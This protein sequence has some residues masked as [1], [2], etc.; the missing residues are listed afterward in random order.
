ME[1]FRKTV[2]DF[3]QKEVIPNASAWERERGYPRG[4]FPRLG[5]LGYLGIVYPEEYGGM[6]GDYLMA[7][8]FVEEL[9]QGSASLTAGAVVTSLV[10]S[11]PIFRFGTEEQRRRYLVPAIRGEKVVAFGLTEPNAGSDVAGIQTLARREG[12]CYVLSGRKTFITN[13]DIADH[14]VV[15]AV[16][17]RGQGPKGISLFIVERDIPGFSVSRRMETMGWCASHTAELLFEDCRVPVA[18]L[19]GKEN[20]GFY[21]LMGGLNQG[22]ICIGAMSV[23]LAQA[24]LDEALR[25]ARERSQF[26][27]TLSQ[28]QAIRFKLA[29][30]AT[31]IEAARKLLHWAAETV[32]GDPGGGARAS[33]MAKLFASEMANRVVHEAFQVFGGYGY[34]VKYPIERLYRDVRV[35]KIVEGTSRSPARDHRQ[36]ARTMNH[37]GA[38]G[39]GREAT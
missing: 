3:V 20:Q 14:V 5:E 22:R 8:L 23:G 6:G 33:S 11:R 29:D 4:L 15:A 7:A 10:G 25:Y 34:T 13:G 12:D 18:N 9:A 31:E 1:L 36:A 28:F 39:K 17:D 27:R 26:G 16:T 35:L 32:D 24:A 37:K 38:R 21:H 19:L 2:R 30:I